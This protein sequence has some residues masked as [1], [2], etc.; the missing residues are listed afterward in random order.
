MGLPNELGVGRINRLLNRLLQ[1][2]GGSPAPVLVPELQATILL[3]G[4]RLEWEWLKGAQLFGKMR[5]VAA[6]VATFSS[7][8]LVN[9]ANSGVLATIIALGVVSNADVA[10]VELDTG[11]G[12]GGTGV[13][14]N[15]LDTRIESAVGSALITQTLTTGGAALA[16]PFWRL[17]ANQQLFV[18]RGLCVM[19][20]GTL[21]R[22]GTNAVNS[23][24]QFLAI[25]LER[26]IEQSEVG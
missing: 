17:A 2:K 20:Q 19:T 5:A 8:E 14:G 23:G 1:I 15:R 6:G 25:W 11:A 16:N 10:D 12:L 18:P 13:R 21:L 24:F 9:P 4:D 7:V 3:E 22:M 26:A